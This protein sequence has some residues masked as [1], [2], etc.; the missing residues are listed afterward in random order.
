MPD[1]LVYDALFIGFIP[2]NLAETGGL[3]PEN[4]PEMTG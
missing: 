3:R 1:C 2:V 4:D